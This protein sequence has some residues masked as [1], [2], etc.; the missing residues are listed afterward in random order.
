MWFI[1]GALALVALAA[2]ARSDASSVFD[3]PGIPLAVGRQV[4]VPPSA[5]VGTIVA[6][7][8]L[9]LSGGFGGI[10]LGFDYDIQFASGI[11]HGVHETLIQPV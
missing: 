3:S 8:N 6:S 7:H 2:K 4:V 11:M 5:E 9:G 1:L 10:P